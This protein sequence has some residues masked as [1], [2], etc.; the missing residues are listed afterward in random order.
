MTNELRRVYLN[1]EPFL[2]DEDA[3]LFTHEM[4]RTR[5]LTEEDLERGGGIHLASLR[6]VSVKGIAWYLDERLRELRRVAEPTTVLTYDQF[7][8]LPERDQALSI[9]KGAAFKRA[10]KKEK[11]YRVE[12]QRL[13]DADSDCE[14]G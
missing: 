2:H 12:Q 13:H 1:N 11:A 8:L 6:V 4:D 10:M 7:D 3:K 14:R 5:T 9:P